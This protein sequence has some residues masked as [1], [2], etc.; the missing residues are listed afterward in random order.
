M[1][2]LVLFDYDQLDLDTRTTLKQRAERINERSRKMA[3][4]IW[5]IGR[6]FAEA[7]GELAKH[8]YG[9]FLSWAKTETGYSHQ[10][11]YNYIRVYENFEFKTVLETNVSPKV[12]YA[13]A[14]PS[15]PDE[16]RQEAIDRAESG[17]TITHQKA[18]G[19]I[20][21]HH[22]DPESTEAETEVYS[23]FSPDP[24]GGNTK[25]DG[26]APFNYKRDNKANQAKDIY[27]PKGYD[28][29]QTPPYALDP[30]LPY[31]NR[32]WLI[33]ESAAGEG[34]LVEAFYDSGFRQ[35][36]VI[37]TDLLTG[38]NFF[39]FTPD[40]WDCQVTNPP[41][42]I[43]Y[44][45]LERCYQLGKPFALLVPVEMLGAKTAQALLEKYGFEMM[46]LDQRV[47]FKMPVKGWDSSAQFPTFWLCWQLLP[48]K[49]M[50]GKLQKVEQQD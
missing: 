21:A 2:Q 27:K 4:D 13:L 42:S 36:Q 31:L 38:Q 8:G 46:L 20:A 47:D 50:F 37:G 7:Q 40:H 25:A 16:A 32:D 35:T 15:T 5:E 48:E 19:I 41:Y 9:C 28:V 44:E 34:Y 23:L 33:W 14:A 26:P 39:D 24:E 29:C 1:D 17:E 30:L 6:E 49:I 10:T 22:S 3:V 12:L 18:Q 43:K 45:W 11:V